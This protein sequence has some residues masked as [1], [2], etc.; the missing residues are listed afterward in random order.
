MFI[1]H[2]NHSHGIEF[3]FFKVLAFVRTDKGNNSPHRADC[4]VCKCLLGFHT[5]AEQSDLMGL[6]AYLPCSKIPT[7][8]GAVN[9]LPIRGLYDCEYE[10]ASKEWIKPNFVQFFL[11]QNSFVR[12]EKPTCNT[13]I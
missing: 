1:L 5:K 6:W 11:V 12:T 4:H 3:I 10:L 2:L 8:E 7:R 13:F 9:F